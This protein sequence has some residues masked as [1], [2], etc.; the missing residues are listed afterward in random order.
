MVV[1]R[2]L[3]ERKN[4]LLEPTDSTSIEILIERRR[5]GQT[6]L[7]VKAGVSG[8]ANATKP[9]NMGTFD[10]AHL[11]VPLPKDLTGSGIFSRN[12]MSAFP[13]SY[14]LMRRSSDGYISA[15]G[16]FKA[17]FPWAS[18][19]EE[20][21]ERKYQKTFPSAGDEEV[22]GSVWIAPEEALALSE[23]YSMRHWI[24]A[25]LDPA[26]IEKGGKD[27]SNAAIQMPPRF[28]VANAQPATLPTFGFRQTRARSARSVSPSKAMTPGRKYATPRKGR[29]TRSAMKPDATHADDMF[30]PIEAVTPST[31]LQ[32]SIA[33]RIAPAET[34]ASSIEGEVKE[35]EQEVKAALDA[36]K[37]PEPELEVQEGTVHI[38]VKQTVETNGDTEKTSTSVTVDV[39]HDHAALPEPEDPTAMIEEAKRMVAEAQKLEGGS[40]S[41]T[42]SSKRGIEEVLDEEDLADERLNKLAKKAYT[43]EQ[44]MTKEKVT[45]RA[46]VGLGVMAAIGTA[47][48][49]FV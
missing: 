33:R 34:I 36:E 48:Q 4:P 39:P 32:N 22:A 7:G 38:E 35:V 10:Y 20:D 17:A 5:L 15:T 23:E 1:D 6:N 46:L 8:I 24:E 12:R 31:A 18:L 47:F 41:V 2:V 43:T 26:P 44:K 30:R 9:E 27:K 3:P 19:Q 37:K 25:L 13:E 42:R 11:R 49:Y 45:R 28:D 29:S 40:P 14:F 16:M 21:L